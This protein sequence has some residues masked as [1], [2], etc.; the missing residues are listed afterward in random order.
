MIIRYSSMAQYFR[1]MLGM[2]EFDGRQKK[3]L[4]K[5]NKHRAKQR[6]RSHRRIRMGFGK[7]WV[8]NQNFHYANLQGERRTP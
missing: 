2:G 5:T 3:V 8:A 7:R 6:S 4:K 1:A